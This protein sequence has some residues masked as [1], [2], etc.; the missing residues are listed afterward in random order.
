MNNYQYALENYTEVRDR[1]AEFYLR[2]P[3]GSLQFE[4]N[5]T[6]EIGGQTIIWGRAYA[7]RTPDDIRP[8]VGTAWEFVPGKTPFTRGSE[9]QNLET[10]AWGRAIGSLNIGMN[11]QGIATKEEV[12]LAKSRDPWS[13]PPDS[14]KKAEKADSSAFGVVYVGEQDPDRKVPKKGPTV[15]NMD[16]PASEKQVNY[17]K[18]LVYKAWEAAGYE[19]K[20]TEEELVDFVNTITKSSFAKISDF[21][22]R[23]VSE[24]LDDQAN[25]QTNLMDWNKDARLWQSEVF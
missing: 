17:F 15:S 24:I 23:V 2:Y 12:T 20:P 10:S 16:R 22:S 11:G 8:G 3:E 5:G 1:V 14:P 6:M 4:F 18:S 21:T 7:Y 9:L 13:A 25:L 19:G